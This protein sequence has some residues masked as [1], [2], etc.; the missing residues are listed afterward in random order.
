[1][2]S[3]LAAAPARPRATQSRASHPGAFP[4]CHAA[5]P[6]GPLWAPLRLLLLW[7]GRASQRR[8]LAELDGRLLTDMG[9][10]HEEARAEAAKPFWRG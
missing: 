10:T 9:L 1:M 7:Q 3:L 5:P 8:H 4:A 6:K 2:P